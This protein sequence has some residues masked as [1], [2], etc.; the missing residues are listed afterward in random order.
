MLIISVWIRDLNILS[1]GE[2]RINN[3]RLFHNLGPIIFIVFFLWFVNWK[4]DE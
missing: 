4:T 3:D 2:S 1:D